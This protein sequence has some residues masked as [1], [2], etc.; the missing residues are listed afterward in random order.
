MNYALSNSSA[1]SLIAEMNGQI[2]GSNFLWEGDPIAG[3]GPIT[4]DP[5]VQNA[6]TGRKLMEAAI[7]R[8]DEQGL[9]G[10]R[11]VQAAYHN[12]SLSLYAKLGF[13][14]RE[15]L[16]VIQGPALDIQ[17]AGYN[18]RQA[19]EADLEKC[20][21]LCHKIHGHN[22]SNELLGTIWA[23]TASVVEY[24]GKI[25]G[26]TSQLGFLGHTVAETYDALKAIIGA[27][28]VFAGPGFLL[29]S[30]N[31]EVLL[32]CLNNGLRIVQPM[33]LMTKGFYKEPAGSFLP[34]VLY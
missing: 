18:V 9:A 3:V 34:S 4:I 1:Y 17:F 32:W 22:R 13:E 10:V 29:P 23:G 31:A 25:S 20:N 19:K 24:N 2:V 26:Y 21:E 14:V 16:S 27:A 15:P 6:S 8:A 30:R 28:T 33:T 11:L 12:R 7:Q 5:L